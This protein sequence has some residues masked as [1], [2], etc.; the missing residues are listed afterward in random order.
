MSRNPA[1]SIRAKLCGTLRILSRPCNQCPFTG[2]IE[3]SPGRL[4]EI[5]RNCHRIGKERPFLCHKTAGAGRVGRTKAAVCRGFHDKYPNCSAA[6]Q[7]AG[8]LNLIE[9]VEPPEEIEPWLPDSV[10]E[11]R[12]EAP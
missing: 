4:Q 3:L 10:R 12:I 7:I 1:T 11:E 8:R 2:G 5:V 9:W 6:Q